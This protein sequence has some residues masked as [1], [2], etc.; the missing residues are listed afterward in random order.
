PD[1]IVW[2]AAGMYRENLV[3]PDK[4]L[5]VL[6]GFKPGFGARTNACGTILEA[7]NAAQPVL[8]ADS[9][10]S[11]FAMEGLSVRR[12]ARGLSVAGDY[13]GTA[14]FTVARCVFSENGDTS[15]IGGALSLDNVNA[16]IFQSVFRDNRASKGA[17]LSAS[18]NVTL[19]VDQNLFDRNLGYSDHGGGLYLSAKSTKLVRNTFRANATGVAGQ[20][21]W[22]GAVI[23]YKSG[24]QP[25]SADFAFNVFTEN[26]AGI[27]GAVFV[28]DGAN[29]TMSHDLLYRNRAYP[30]NGVV[31]GPALYVDGTGL[32]PAGGSTLVG[33]FLTVVDNLYDNNGA[34]ASA[35]VGGNVY[36]EGFSKVSF[37]SSIFW[38]NGDRAF[39][40]AP[41]QN[42]IAVK[43]SISPSQCTS[44]DNKGWTTASAATCKV[45]A[46]VFLPSAIYFVDEAGA[47]FHEKSTAG[48]YSNGLWVMDSVTSPAIDKG[49]PAAS[50]GHESMPNGGRANLGVFAGTKE[51]SKSP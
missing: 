21:G 22:G 25:A 10:V 31:R 29:V 49:D 11:S 17:A 4:A 13:V 5:L 33:E 37:T 48:H 8:S 34:P 15:A 9:G 42:E 45:G 19:T 41:N 35:S 1:G 40:A 43:S 18:G 6:G 50:V 23:V 12:G 20:G 39:Y 28:D 27:G 44:S 32:G 47:D 3:I 38:N 7:A 36:V 26:V 2:I 30:E 51:A 24:A 46:G 14:T 16:R